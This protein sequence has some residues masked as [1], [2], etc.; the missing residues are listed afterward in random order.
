MSVI[1]EVFAGLGSGVLQGLGTLAKDLR[2]AI[3]GAEAIPAETQGKLLEI[4]AQVEAIKQTAD[5]ELQKAQIA[6]NAIDAQSGSSYR[7]GWRPLAGW[8]AVFAVV[9]YPIIQVVMPWGI[10]TAGVILGKDVSHL[11]IL[12]TLPAST[13]ADLLWALLGLGGLRSFDKLKGNG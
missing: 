4:A 1:A 2:T 5:F 11:P 10:A 6:I 13:Q 8:A 3:T 9:V 12:P 7:G